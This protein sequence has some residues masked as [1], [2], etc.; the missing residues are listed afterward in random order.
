MMS[1]PVSARLE[2]VQPPAK[3]RER[4]EIAKWDRTHRGGWRVMCVCGWEGELA[5]LAPRYR[6][7]LEALPER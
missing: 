7:A 5:D 2:V 4:H 3:P 6:A 1:R